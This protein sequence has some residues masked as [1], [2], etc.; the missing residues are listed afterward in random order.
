MPFRRK[1][2]FKKKRSFRKK[3]RT[4][5]KKKRSSPK[6]LLRSKVIIYHDPQSNCSAFPDAYYCT[7]LFHEQAIH[8]SGAAFS[9]DRWT[10]N[11]LSAS[12]A[13][14]SEPYNEF[15]LMNGL[16]HR[17]CCM[18]W[19]YKVTILSTEATAM[20][21]CVIP[22]ARNVSPSNSSVASQREG[23]NIRSVLTQGGGSAS[24]TIISGH[25]SVKKLFGIPNITSEVDFWGSETTA[26]AIAAQMFLTFD[27]YLSIT[28]TDAV[29]D[30]E[31][32]AYCKWFDRR[33]VAVS[34]FSDERKKSF[35]SIKHDALIK[36]RIGI[37]VDTSG[38]E[39]VT[40]KRDQLVVPKKRRIV[41]TLVP[42]VEN[43]YEMQCL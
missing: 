42:V 9:V 20:Q 35:A 13:G 5:R 17:W 22:W 43:D 1:R 21:I 7:M 2:T 14:G 16:Y 29:Y 18:A 4:V 33:S 30:M 38:G 19:D 39:N 37:P 11:T 8:A 6:Q 24:K 27:N 28:S 26:P 40:I 3:R 23:A 32:R 36:S 41:P 15:D 12:L 25:V 10:P 31:L 34:S